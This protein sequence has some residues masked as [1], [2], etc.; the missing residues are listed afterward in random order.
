MRRIGW[1]DVDRIQNSKCLVVGAGALGNEAVKCMVL[2]GFRRIAVVDMDSVAVSNLSRCVLFRD[3]DA[4]VNKAEVVARR[5]SELCP[6]ACVAPLAS[7]VQELKDWDYDI[8]FGCLDNI[9]ARLHTN[10][11]ACFHGI[12]YID[13]GTDGFRG[14]VQVVLPGGPCLECAVNKSHMR[15]LDSR[16]SC[17]GGGTVFVP[18]AAAEITTASVIAAM[19]V[20][21]AIKILSGKSD[22][23]IRGICYY[24][25][26]S[27]ESDTLTLSVDPACPNHEETL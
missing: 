18:K 17:T 8:V 22:L 14:K 19:Q 25:G 2:A 12:P 6:D 21:E 26:E 1:L 3:E 27:C 23:C 10:S 20:R 13:G 11:H 7:K 24:N 9:S 4:G 16:F 15:V 5:A